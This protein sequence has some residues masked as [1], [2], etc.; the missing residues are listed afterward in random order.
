MLRQKKRKEYAFQRQFNEKPT[1]L[2]RLR[3][4]LL[5]CLDS[6]TCAVITFCKGIGL[7]YIDLSRTSLAHHELESVFVIIIIH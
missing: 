2:P 1:G 7:V 4:E 6:I 5:H 3:H